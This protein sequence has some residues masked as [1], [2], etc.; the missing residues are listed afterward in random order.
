MA[1]AGKYC[2]FSCPQDDFGIKN[3]DDLCPGCGRPY[4]YELRNPP[5][6]IGDY[7]VLSSLGRGFYGVT[8]VAEKRGGLLESTS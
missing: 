2:C 6:E 5:K 7:R 3:I 4:D 1:S 8:F